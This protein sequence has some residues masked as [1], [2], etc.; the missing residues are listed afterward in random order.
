M[1]AT[2]TKDLR[3]KSI[4]DLEQMVL[5]ERAALYRDR[6][7]LAFRTITD[8]ARLKTRRKNVARLLTLIAEKKREATS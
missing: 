1:Q 4:E 2:K 3:S 5:E 6:R 8:T 7:D